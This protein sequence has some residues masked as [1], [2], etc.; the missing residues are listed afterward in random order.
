M[1]EG[2][3]PAAKKLISRVRVARSEFPRSDEMDSL[4]CAGRSPEA[5]PA[6]REW[7]DL[8]ASRTSSREEYGAALG[9]GG[10]GGGGD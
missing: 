10:V 6:E 5:P 8:R 3:L 7:K 1:D 2:A 9:G 4:K